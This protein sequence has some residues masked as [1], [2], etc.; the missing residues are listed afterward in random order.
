MKNNYLWAFLAFAGA[1]AATYFIVRIS[2]KGK[3][4]A[5]ARKLALQKSGKETSTDEG[6]MESKPMKGGGFLSNLFSGIGEALD[7]SRTVAE[8]EGFERYRVNT[9]STSLN[10]RQR[11]SSTSKIVGS[12]QKNEYFFGKPSGAFVE[13]FSVNISKAEPEYTS[14]GFVSASFVKKD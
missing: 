4:E 10:I 7:Y 1:G 8:A 5:E 11:P 12:L 13:V 6:K 2:S 3:R 9:A 14:R